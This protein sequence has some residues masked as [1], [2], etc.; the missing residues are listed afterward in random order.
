MNTVKFWDRDG[1][2]HRVKIDPRLR[3]ASNSS[4]PSLAR[5]EFMAAC[6][7]WTRRGPKGARARK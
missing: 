4:R 1:K 6:N 5:A 7:G 2:L 3:Y